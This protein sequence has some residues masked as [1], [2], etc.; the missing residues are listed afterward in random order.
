MRGAGDLKS[1][2]ADGGDLPLIY[3]GIILMK[4]CP[5]PGKADSQKRK[6]PIGPPK[7]AE[8]FRINGELR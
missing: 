6:D 2:K 7:N 8:H 5:S 1:K 3:P 4:I